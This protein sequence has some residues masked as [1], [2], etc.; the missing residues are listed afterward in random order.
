LTRPPA[1]VL[2]HSKK[3][4]SGAAF[5]AAATAKSLTGEGSSS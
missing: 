1:L 3:I 4:E 5:Q 2:H